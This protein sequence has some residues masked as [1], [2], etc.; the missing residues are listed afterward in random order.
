LYNLFRF[1]TRK[2]RVHENEHERY[3]CI[4]MWC[5]DNDNQDEKS[6]TLKTHMERNESLIYDYDMDAK[7]ENKGT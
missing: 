2:K 7:T 6:Y 4:E 5:Q 3:K 1:A